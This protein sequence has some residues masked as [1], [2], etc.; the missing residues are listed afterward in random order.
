M[1]I[2]QT[3]TIKNLKLN[4]KRTIV[5]IIGI[6]L[7][8]ALIVA[9]SSLVFSFRASIIEREKKV[10]GDFHYE[11]H[12]VPKDEIKYITNNRNV[13]K[14]YMTQ[15]IGYAK[16][17]NSKNEDKPYLYLQEFSK[18]ALDNLGINLIEG[19]L[20]ENE[21][22]I[23]ISNHIKTNARV[24]YNIGDTL[25]LKIGDRKTID[26]YELKQSNPYNGKY[27]GE[28]YEEHIEEK[29]T[30]TYT[31]VGIM[32]RPA[33]KIE[34]YSAPGYTIITYLNENN[35]AEKANVFVR[36][37]KEGLKNYHKTTANILG[38]SEK[39]LK[40]YGNRELEDT[41]L[42]KYSYSSNTYLIEYETLEFSDSLMSMIYAVSL[43][44]VAII[45]ATSVFCIRNSFSIS[46]TEKVK[47]YGMLASVGAT[48]KQ[49]K[50]NVYFES[51]MLAI[52]GIP[53]GIVLGLVASFI[54]VK[55]CNSLL[56]GTL[57]FTLAYEVS[58]IAILI[59]LVL[60]VITCI[61]SA[62]SSAKR[63]SKIA[64]ID[65][66]RES[67]DIKIK[68]KK[69]KSPRFIKNCFGIGGD[70]AYKNLKRNNKKYRTTVISI[71]VCVAV[72]IATSSFVDLAFKT[73]GIQIQEVDYNIAI[74][75]NSENIEDF[76]GKL[77]TISN[78]DNIN[79]YTIQ[80]EATIKTS[81]LKYN[82]E[83]NEYRNSEGYNGSDSYISVYSI[84]KDEYNRYISE[85]GLNYEECKDK[86]ILINTSVIY[87]EDE[88]GN[89][90]KAEIN[91]CNNKKGD[92][93]NA[94][95]VAMDNSNTQE[96]QIDIEI[97]AVVDNKPMGM[98]NL[99]AGDGIIIVSDEFIDKYE[100]YV[101][102]YIFMY[103]DS[104]N[105]DKLQDDIDAYLSNENGYYID[106]ID[107]NMR[108]MKSLYL[109]VAIFLYGFIAV[110][111]LIG[112]TNIF[113]T[114]T[115]SME[116]RAKEFA[117]LKSVGMTKKEFNKMIKLENFFYG[118]KSLIIGIPIGIILSYLIF[119]AL[120]KGVEFAYFLP[121]NAI[122]IS[123]IAVFLL[124]WSIMRFSLNKINKQ[125][126]IETIR[127]DNI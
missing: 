70:I 39:T 122:L 28:E 48:S 5:T 123:L 21:N 31:I 36:Y 32:E 23:V 75:G 19:R 66:I 108:S 110:I 95:I 100:E 33:E 10:S 97:G 37:D 14:V 47:Q 101:R 107:Q 24:K 113:N 96:K 3:L 11:F 59:S 53:L 126:I 30:K 127:R 2:L 68:G 84:G 103:I 109:L 40:D 8:T 1:N 85:I 12:D 17:E 102:D 4:K 54:L 81:S 94:K 22:E 125:N 25:T 73:I 118:T 9:L 87:K 13:E 60:S 98:K 57:E 64:P 34:P 35:I 63:A 52:I 124:V 42:I 90:K 78:F 58:V 83:Y 121:V 104:S 49:I 46:I 112:I 116:L 92:I 86:A 99:Y 41:K 45:I 79:K 119:K 43:I 105:A 20:P 69:V 111:A 80:R 16:L 89:F 51:L 115:T 56:I 27:D 55:I 44:V 91:L 65:A 7:A 62:R 76:L 71:V 29:F 18:D 114:I 74:R 72:F 77:E 61:L 88:N 117:M 15:G 38:V 6:M 67:A 26:G 50:K 106:N 82:N 93:I 120:S